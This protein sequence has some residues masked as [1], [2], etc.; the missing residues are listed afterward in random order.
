MLFC[1]DASGGG[2]DIIAMIVK[3]YSEMDIE[4]ALILVDLLLQWEHGLYTA[5][6]PD[7]FLYAV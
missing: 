3:K 1:Y 5:H 7:Y 2:T 6:R 4:T